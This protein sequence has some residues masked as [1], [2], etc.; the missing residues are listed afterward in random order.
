M[1]ADPQAS[2]RRKGEGG[3]GQFNDPTSRDRVTLKKHGDSFDKR[4]RDRIVRQ[5]RGVTGRR[6]GPG[7]PPSDAPG[8]T[9]PK[10]RGAL[11]IQPLERLERLDLILADFLLA[12]AVARRDHAGALILPLADAVRYARVNRNADIEA[13]LQR[14]TTTSH[15]SRTQNNL[16]LKQKPTKF[17]ILIELCSERISLHP[18]NSPSFPC[19]I[20]LISALMRSSCGKL[21]TPNINFSY[22]FTFFPTQALICRA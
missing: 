18:R 4:A 20:T 13:G 1:S 21:F 9:L 16:F 22:F 3:R 2:P 7:N 10:R 11:E 12:H 17:Y 5:R 19:C 8:P 6:L 14:L 15:L